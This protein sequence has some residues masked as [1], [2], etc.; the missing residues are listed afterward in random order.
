MTMIDPRNRDRAALDRAEQTLFDRLHAIQAQASG[1]APFATHDAGGQW[2]EIDWDD[3][4]DAANACAFALL[5]RGLTRGDTIAI[6]AATHPNWLYADM[7]AMMAGVVSAGIYPTEPA[8]KVEYIVSDC[9]ARILFVDTDAQIEK[10]LAL[11]GRCPRLETIVVLGDAAIPDHPAFVAFDRFLADG[12]AAA[13]RRPQWLRDAATR[14]EPEDTA[15]LIYTSGTTGP[16]KGAMIPH[17][18]FCY[19]VAITPTPL[20]MQAGWRRLSYLPMCHVAERVF[21]YAAMA[22]G[23]TNYFVPDMERLPA[24]LREVRPQHFIAV[25]RIYEKLR[26]GA[27][28]WIDAQA[29]DRRDILRAS[30]ESAI[31]HGGADGL[32]QEMRSAVE[33][34]RTAIGLER[35]EVAVSGGAQCT[36]EIARWQRGVGAPP[37]DL[38]GMTEC[39]LIALNFEPSEVVGTVG[40]PCAHGD[41]RIADDGEICVR[42]SHVFNGYLNLPDKTAEALQDGWFHTGDVGRF[43]A[44]GRLVLIDRIKDL[45]ITSGGKNIAPSLIEGAIKAS[46]YIDQAIVV[47]ESRKFVAALVM[48]DEAAVRS[49]IGDAVPRDARFADLAAAPATHRLVAAAIDTANA[50][51]SRAESVRDFRI[52]PREIGSQD[53]LFT[54]TMKVKR[55][56]AGRLFADLIADIY[57]D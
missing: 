15:M 52:V 22:A 33:D 13:G 39:G 16:P 2:R 10:A 19:Q 1:H 24:A 5:D 23:M 51:F 12:R 55:P 40:T 37:A 18:A 42:G 25:P 49:A 50:G 46:P 35:V 36:A 53:D 3:A 9:A 26:L 45:I 48:I 7:G 8:A 17:R 54:P 31:A 32:P 14:V 57:A 44:Q 29:P 43:D 11:L 47:G 4:M 27:E 30:L 34:I 21:T 56:V 28:A 6:L 20:R 41:V 38:Y